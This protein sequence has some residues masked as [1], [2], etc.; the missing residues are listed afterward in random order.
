MAKVKKL[1]TTYINGEQVFNFGGLIPPILFPDPTPSNTPTPTLTKTPTPTPTLTPTSS[2]VLLTPTPTN[3]MTLTKTPTSTP[4]PTPTNT[5]FKLDIGTGF[6]GDVSAVYVDDSINAVYVGGQ[7]VGYNGQLSCGLAKISTSGVLDTA[8]ASNFPYVNRGATTPTKIF[9]D[10]TGDYIYVVGSMTDGRI[11]KIHKLT[12]VNVWAG[13]TTANSTIYGGCVDMLTGDVYL[14]GQFINYNGITRAR[15]C[16]VDKDGNLDTGAFTGSNLNNTATD[17]FFNNNGNLVVYGLFSSYNGG[18]VG[19]IIEIETTTYTNTG[20]FGSGF[21]GA[22]YGVRQHPADNTYLAGGFYTTYQGSG[23][24]SYLSKIDEFGS[25]V[26]WTASLPLASQVVG[27]ELDVLN[28][29]IIVEAPFEPNGIVLLDYVSGAQDPIF[30]TNISN[31]IEEYFDTYGKGVV[32][33]S[34]NRYYFGGN[35]TFWNSQPLSHLVRVL[36]DGTLNTI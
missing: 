21:N 7:F 16:K 36:N 12:G 25:Y 18:S 23:T 26:S 1:E 10:E 27:I 13:L 29:K 35:F 30:T 8:F 20:L 15:I 31:V 11:W 33:D 4:S 28:N 32:I 5:P 14:V 2:S 24:S 9:P 6:D 19:R 22:V 17:C 3:T 34:L